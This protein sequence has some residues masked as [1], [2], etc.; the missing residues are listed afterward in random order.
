VNEISLI[1]YYQEREKKDR[2]MMEGR[3]KREGREGQDTYNRYIV[4][5]VG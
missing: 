2:N 1:I 4:K 5:I 3:G